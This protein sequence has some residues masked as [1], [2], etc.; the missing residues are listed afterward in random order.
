MGCPRIGIKADTRGLKELGEGAAQ[1]VNLPL[2][3]QED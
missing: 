1:E 3:W 2:C